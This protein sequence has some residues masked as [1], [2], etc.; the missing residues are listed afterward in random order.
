VH[1]VQKVRDRGDN[2]ELRKRMF[3]LVT[4]LEKLC[5]KILDVGNVSA[6]QIDPMTAYLGVKAVDSFRDTD[7]RAVLGP[8]KDLAEEMRIAIIAVMHFN[9]KVDI[10]NALLRI[11]NSLAFVGLPRHVY[12]VINDDEN[13]RKL[14][15][16]VKNNDAARSAN[17]TLAFS[18][19]EKQ[20]G[21]DARL[22]KP[23]RAP[24]IVWENGYVDISATEA[25]QAVSESKAP[26]ERDKA[27]DLL[28]T[29]LADGREVLLEEI[30]DTSKG[31]GLSWR[32]VRRASE[33]LN[34]IPRKDRTTPKGKWFWKLPTQQ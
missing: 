19:E 30:Q 20:V 12:G 22:D 27:K 23:I 32:T 2:G 7:V 26:G 15:V 4:D 8:L 33:E 24:F 29:L 18:F 11:S 6:V 9:K 16:R 28:R 25:M 5:K 1:F 31:H 21:F 10:T 13:D 3:S 34:V 14:V 17:Q